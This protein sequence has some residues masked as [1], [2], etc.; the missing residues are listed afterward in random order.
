V[1]RVQSGHDGYT[2]PAGQIGHADQ[3][4]EHSHIHSVWGG[5][6]ILPGQNGLTES[7]PLAAI[8][9]KSAATSEWSKSPHQPIAIR[10]GQ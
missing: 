6:E 8:R 7:K 1:T 10:A 9:E 3:P 2:R 5:L 4:T